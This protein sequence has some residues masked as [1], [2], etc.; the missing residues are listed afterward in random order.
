MEGVALC[1]WAVFDVVMTTYSCLQTGIGGHDEH[2]HTQ[3]HTQEPSIGFIYMIV[4]HFHAGWVWLLYVKLMVI[5]FCL[6][7][8]H[9]SQG[10]SLI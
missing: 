10:K 6:E 4:P 3:D 9:D 5:H 8:A 7:K 2:L 1:A